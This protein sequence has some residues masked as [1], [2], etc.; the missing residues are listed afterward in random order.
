M[1]VDVRQIFQIWSQPCPNCPNDLSGVWLVYEAKVVF[2]F[3]RGVF[4]KLT[5]CVDGS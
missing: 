1:L 2:V 3:M 5:F 4:L